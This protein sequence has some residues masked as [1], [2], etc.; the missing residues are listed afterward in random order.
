M[1]EKNS[2][3]ILLLAY[4]FPNWHVDRLNE[5]VHGEGWTEWEVLKCARSRFPG[6][7]QPRIPVWGMKTKQN[8]K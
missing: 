4:Y 6:H 1:N 2:E 5:T 7:Y 8:P 3:K